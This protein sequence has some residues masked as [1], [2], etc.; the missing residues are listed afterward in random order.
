MAISLSL[1]SC[2]TGETAPQKNEMLLLSNGVVRLG[3]I[4]HTHTL[5]ATLING[6][7]PIMWKS[8]NPEIATCEGGVI[9]SVGFGKCTI[10]AYTES[11][12]SAFC[13]VNVV[14]DDAGIRLEDVLD[15]SVENL[16]VTVSSYDKN[17]GELRVEYII[18]SYTISSKMSN[19]N[20]YIYVKLNGIK[21]Y[22][23][24]GANGQK[25]VVI[26]LG[27]YREG[28]ELCEYQSLRVTGV[29]VGERFSVSCDVFGLVLNG[30]KREMY[31]EI[32]EEI[33]Q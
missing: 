10:T 1:V 2:D 8:S 9:T 20:Y 7:A 28:D 5:V 4:G 15:F 11:G 31:M 23:V 6:D 19:G 14:D 13:V 24:D 30:E 29:R 33:E 16:P 21:T 3:G 27:L 17:T 26:K 25:P 22:D 18:E 12:I 32:S